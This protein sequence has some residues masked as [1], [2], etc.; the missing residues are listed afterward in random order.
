MSILIDGYNLLHHSGLLPRRLGPGGLERA[1]RALLGTLGGLLTPDE[2]AQT[3]IVFDAKESPIDGSEK[4]QFQ[5]IQV[6]YAV[7]YDEADELLEELIRRDPT[8][9]KLLVVSSDL[10]V[11]RAARRRRAQS[12]ASETWFDSLQQR[13]R[14]PGHSARPPEKPDPI[15]DEVDVD[16]WLRNFGFEPGEENRE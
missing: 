12:E 11:R 16:Y 4:E 9:K 13:R 10:R 8:P 5:G 7:E 2:A 15:S 1:R 6:R 14:T 3:V